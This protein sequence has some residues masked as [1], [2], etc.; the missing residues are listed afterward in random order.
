MLLVLRRSTVWGFH[1]LHCENTNWYYVYDCKTNTWD[2][3]NTSSSPLD[4]ACVIRL[5]NQNGSGECSR[6]QD[7]IKMLI[8]FITA[9]LQR[10]LWVS[11]FKTSHN[12]RFLSGRG[13]TSNISTIN[14]SIAM[15]SWNCSNQICGL[16]AQQCTK[17]PN[18]QMANINIYIIY[19]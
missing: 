7:I 6:L 15:K 17:L 8:A 2:W 4:D 11:I 16:M 14:W 1:Y 10:N 12:I 3:L 9:L 13:H 5:Q 18:D 19:F